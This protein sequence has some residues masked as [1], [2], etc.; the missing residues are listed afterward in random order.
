MKPIKQK[1]DKKQMMMIKK[2]ME[3]RAKPISDIYSNDE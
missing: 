2:T 3:K 1:I